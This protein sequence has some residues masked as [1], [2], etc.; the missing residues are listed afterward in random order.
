[1]ATSK[2]RKAKR[3]PSSR[4]EHVPA[5]DGLH[6]QWDLPYVKLTGYNLEVRGRY[7]F[8]GD[9]AS[10]RA[11]RKRLEAL[12]RV[13]KAGQM[14]PVRSLPTHKTKKKHLDKMLAEG[15]PIAGAVVH[16]AV[17]AFAQSL[18]EVVRR[19]L[20][21]KS[22]RRVERIVVGGGLSN[23]RVGELA[24]GRAAILLREQ[25]AR[26]KGS[27]RRERKVD[28]VPLT[29]HP[30]EAG[31]IGSVYLVPR[32]ILQGYN[33]LLTV[34]IGGTNVR[35]GVVTFKAGRKA[36][37]R[38][39]GVWKSELWSH[40]KHQ[41]TRDELIAHVTG[42]LTH[43][44]KTARK[45]HLKLAPV[46]GVGCPGIIRGDGSIKRGT[47]NLP[48][49]WQGRKFNLPLA[50]KEH[51]PKIAGHDTL[52]VLHNDAVVQGLSYLPEMR[53]VRAWGVLTVGTGLGNAS[54]ENDD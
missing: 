2:P 28:L 23:S 47:Q 3:R 5:A 33:A 40:R 50:L 35:C 53:D 21:Q 17:E 11:F 29:H 7:G 45:A 48:G 9:Q 18:A 24:I 10:G 4:T 44:E 37:A 46:I 20:K 30:D 31:L 41:P 49:N 22:W 51:L 36:Q 14:A 38:A 16:S 39:T 43:F 8:I 13:A 42:M 54:F 1:M 32:A 15:E 19:Y 26:P 27:K 25:R 34:D 12:S 6:G 52:V